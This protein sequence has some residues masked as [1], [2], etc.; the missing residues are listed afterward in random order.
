[1]Q[2]G[3]CKR[4]RLDRSS[5]GGGILLY[6]R[7]NI[8]SRLLTDF[9]IKDNLEL[10]FVKVN[11]RKKKW[12]L[13]C[14]YNPHKSNISNHLHHLN[15]GLCVYL[16]SYNYILI[17]RDLNSE[18]SENCLNGLCNVNSL[19]T[20][21]RGPSCFKNPNNPSCI[22]L[23]LKNWQQCFQRT[24]AI[25]TGISDFRKILVTVMKTHYKKQKSKNHSIQKL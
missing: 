25:E 21:N 22:D 23:Y 16:K 14:S 4:Y 5:N 20:L 3:F 10:F 1:M 12:L 11:I 7:D 9:E 19:K 24:C 2:N 6:V 8:L 17:M 13:G 18:V 15:K